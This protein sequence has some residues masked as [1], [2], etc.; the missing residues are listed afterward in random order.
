MKRHP[1]AL[2]IVLVAVLAAG[3]YYWLLR[4]PGVAIPPPA[5]PA[6]VPAPAPIVAAPSAPPAASG[7]Q[8]PIEAS[9]AASSPE[10]KGQLNE[11][12]GR[13]AVDSL[14]QT[15]N[16]PR[17]LVA[18]VDNLG[19]GHASP[20]LWPVNPAP[21]RFSVGGT[22]EQPVISPDNAS[23]YAQ[24]LLLLETVDMPQA[25]ATYARLYPQF[26][27]AY[28]ELGYPNGYFNDRLIEVIDL[29]LAT[30]EPEG[31]VQLELPT[32]NA[33][34]QPPRPWVLY[35]F[36]D[37]AL[38]ALPAGQKILLRMGPVNER[39]IKAKLAEFRKLIATPATGR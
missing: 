23:R 29:L 21:G 10:P 16:F 35:Q 24:V 19:R 39:R 1:W 25:A 26:Q 12:F 13:K 2:I 33:P 27:K 3:L 38:E 32:S 22:P 28:E 37:P 17:R 5:T 8:H 11:L 18:T 15:D 9:A 30:P 4:E 34:V 7:I 36:S 31:P 20:R 6:A 14:F